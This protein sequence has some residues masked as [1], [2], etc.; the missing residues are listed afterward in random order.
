MFKIL[1]HS[2]LPHQLVLVTVHASQ[3]TNVS[4]NILK[5]ISQLESIDVVETILDMG[6]DDQLRQTQDFTTKM[7]SISET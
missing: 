6:V 5:T 3:L 2:D 7:E 1:A 4:K